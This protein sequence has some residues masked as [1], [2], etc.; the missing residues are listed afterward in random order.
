MATLIPFAIIA[1][2]VLLRIR[3]MN[4]ERKLNLKTMWAV[5]IVYVILIAFMLTALPPPIVGWELLLAGL[6]VGLLAGWYRG[7]LIHIRRDPESGEL[8]QKASP[9]AMLLLLAII[10]LKVGAR[11]VFGESAA[12]N[13]AS[14]AMLLTDAFIGFALGLLS[15]TRIEMYTRARRLLSGSE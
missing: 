14:P 9:L 1:V 8:R 6:L 4:R 10:I 12:S 7:R 5:P 3:T 11:E 15:A 13:P 2:V